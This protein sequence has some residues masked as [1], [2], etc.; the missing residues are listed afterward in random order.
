MIKRFELTKVT[1]R[2]VAFDDQHV[3]LAGDDSQVAF[4]N[5]GTMLIDGLHKVDFRHAIKGD[6]DINDIQPLQGSFSEGS[7]N[8]FLFITNKGVYQGSITKEIIERACKFVVKID[9]DFNCFSGKHLS[10]LVQ[11]E[12]ST[13]PKLIFTVNNYNSNF[14]IYD[15][16]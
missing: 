14:M 3:M 8:T 5:L 13:G 2:L 4:L 9:R 7:K 16:I 12:T 1:N 10:N 11:L 15:L 6:C